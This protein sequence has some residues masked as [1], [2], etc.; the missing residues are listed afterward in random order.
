MRSRVAPRKIR[1]RGHRASGTLARVLLTLTTTLTPATDLGF[2]LHK[3]PEK[4]QSFP[5]SAGTAHVFYPTRAD[6]RVHRGAAAGGRSDRVG[7]WRS[8]S[9]LSQYVND[10]PYAASSMLAVALGAVF[11]TASTGRCDLTPGAAG[12]GMPLQVHAPVASARGGA[13]LVRRLFEPLGWRVG[14][15]D[16]A[17]VPSATPAMSICGWTAR[18]GWP[19]R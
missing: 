13:E 6:E 17:R 11:R 8:R 12:A 9:G 19:T 2:L 16:P 1:T 5:L 15:A 10:R 4:A 18:C 7:A 3:H 14:D